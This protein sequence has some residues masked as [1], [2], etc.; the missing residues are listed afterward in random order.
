MAA[1]SGLTV[2]QLADETGRRCHRDESGER[3]PLFRPE[4]VCG[5]RSRLGLADRVRP[6]LP[7]VSAVMRAFTD[8]T[9]TG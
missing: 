9:A 4:P 2:W 3:L 7:H 8:L 6:H 5:E 1:G